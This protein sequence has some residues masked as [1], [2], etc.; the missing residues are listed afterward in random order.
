MDLASLQGV[1]VPAIFVVIVLKIVLDA[2]KDKR[3]RSGA[4][5]RA[6]AEKALT[7]DRIERTEAICEKIAE[8]QHEIAGLVRD[9]THNVNR[10]TARCAVA[11]TTPSAGVQALGD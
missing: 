10:M 8:Q 7:A 9:L 2:M 6:V 11:R 5:P 3:A 4:D 1:S